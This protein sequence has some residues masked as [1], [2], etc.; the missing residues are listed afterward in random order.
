MTQAPTPRF[1]SVFQSWILSLWGKCHKNK[2]IPARDAVRLLK[3]VE[4]MRL[5]LV[6]VHGD[7]TAI[8]GK[9]SP[10][11]IEKVK[12]VIFYDGTDTAQEANDDTTA[13]LRPLP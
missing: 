10:E 13:P 11:T 8:Y 3:I 1:D 6:I 5:V 12:R 4:K 7:E 2:S 9:C